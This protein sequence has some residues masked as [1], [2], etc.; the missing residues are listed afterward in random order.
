[1]SDEYIPLGRT[2]HELS[3]KGGD[4]DEFDIGRLWYGKSLEWTALLAEHRVVILSEAGS[5]KTEEIRHA[6]RT[7]RAD[8]KQAFFL[9]LEHIAD[10]F[11]IA[12]EEGS[13]AEFEQWLV[14]DHEGWVFLDSVDEA[15]L[16]EPQDFERAIRK[17]GMRLLTAFDRAH[18]VLTSRGTAWRPVT[19]L[20]LCQR[21]L[22]FNQLRS[23]Q[24]DGEQV[25]GVGNDIV[26]K[27]V[28]L[29]DL[30]AE[31]IA[32]FARA[33]GV[34]DSKPFLNA[35][36]RADAWSMASRPDDLSEL[37]AFWLANCKIGNRLELMQSSITRRLAE[38]DQ[39]RDSAL[40]LSASDAFAGART[41]AAVTTLAHSST[42]RVPD[43]SQNANGLPIAS[44]LPSWNANKC[45]ALLARPIFDEAVYGTVR[46]H[47]RTVREYLT[48]EWFKD[49][50][51]RETSRRRIEGL[52]FREQYGLQVIVPTMRPVLVWL[53]LLDEKVRER[54]LAISP[55]LI[56]EGGEPKALPLEA[57][58]RIL[59]EVCETMHSGVVRGTTTDYRAVQR[60]ADRDIADDIKTLLAQYADNK[61]V[62][63]GRASCRERV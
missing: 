3:L 61:E 55:E 42:I 24:E 44:I 57:R 10:D 9:R 20:A 54:A 48:A 52:F 1:M 27:I 15:R 31:Q 22:P 32:A 6:T 40:P 47:H 12:F 13:L 7:L 53:V 26:F 11:E 43:G 30:N 58:R 38:R 14:S 21:L 2:F 37:V 51:D 29:D 50:L 59:R 18:V 56:F 41:I 35:I 28:A 16:R 36:E 19:D 46:F 62:K 34:T 23:G 33:K 4:S 49:L 63:I 8:G 5:G 17:I 39:N 60:F 45:A 25:E